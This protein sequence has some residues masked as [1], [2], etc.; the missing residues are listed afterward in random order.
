[1][2]A[3]QDI[4]LAIMPLRDAGEFERASALVEARILLADVVAER[5]QLKARL[6]TTRCNSGHDTL[7]LTLWDC[8]ECH[9]ETRAK[10]Q[11]LMLAIVPLADLDLRPDSLDRQPDDRIIY[12]RNRTTI[13]VGDVRRA[14]AALDQ[15]QGGAS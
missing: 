8:P 2:K 15:A 11:A 1:M 3:L 9:N 12:A 6:E 7:P 10:L 5:D 4:E 13:T 14:R